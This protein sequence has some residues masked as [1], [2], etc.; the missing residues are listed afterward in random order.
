MDVISLVRYAG[1]RTS[2]SGTM[3]AIMGLG[4]E[5]VEVVC[6]SVRVWCSR[7]C[8]YNCPRQIV[9]E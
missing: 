3:A 9:I 1:G 5:E 8:K 2:G 7:S 4:K 6:K